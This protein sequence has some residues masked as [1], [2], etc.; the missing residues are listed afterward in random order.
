MELVFLFVWFI[1]KSV[2]VILLILSFFLNIEVFL[3]SLFP[4]ILL[5]LDFIYIIK[6]FSL[7]CLCFL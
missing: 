5:K 3:F 7:K 2:M 1:L 6:A 4:L